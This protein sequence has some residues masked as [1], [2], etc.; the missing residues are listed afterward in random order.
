MKVHETSYSNAYGGVARS[1]AAPARE[2]AAVREGAAP[3]DMAT[4]MGIPEAELTSLGI[5]RS[6]LGLP[7]E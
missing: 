1:G 7:S 3:A 2:G 5:L 4:I 6:P